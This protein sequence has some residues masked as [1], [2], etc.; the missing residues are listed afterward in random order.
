MVMPKTV[1]KPANDH[2]GEDLSFSLDMQLWEEEHV[3]QCRDRFKSVPLETFVGMMRR[4]KKL[5]RDPLTDIWQLGDGSFL[6]HAHAMFEYANS[7]GRYAPGSSPA[8]FETTD[9]VGPHNPLGLIRCTV[10]IRVKAEDGTWHDCPGEA[11]WS[12]LVPLTNARFNNETGQYE[13]GVVSNG[14][15]WASMPH[16]L[17][18]K[19]AYVDALKKAFPELASFF[20]REERDQGA[21]IDQQK[22][23]THTASVGDPTGGDGGRVDART[24]FIEV[25]WLDSDVERVPERDMHERATA[26]LSGEMEERRPE[27][28][29]EW[30]ERNS[31]AMHEFWV[32]DQ[33]MTKRRHVL[34]VKKW[35]GAAQKAMDEAAEAESPVDPVPPPATL[36]RPRRTR[37]GVGA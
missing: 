26:F 21:A 28:V 7:T 5:G 35:L 27:R 20:V 24:Y 34:A 37:R 33:A 32:R 19:C 9:K 1:A 25:D 36:S 29:I 8:V 31:H 3:R 14:T 30:F 18:R 10:S 23:V 13:G 11:F 17:L 4:A 15:G 16:T 2:N 22:P 12:D 6:M